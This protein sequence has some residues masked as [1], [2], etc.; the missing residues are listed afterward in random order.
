MKKLAWLGLPLALGLVACPPPGVSADADKDN[1]PDSAEVPGSSYKGI[2]VYSMGARV[3]QR[4]IFLEIDNMTSAEAKLNPQRAALDKFV[5]AF[6]AK[7]IALHIDVGDAF[8]PNFDPANYNLGNAQRLLPYSQSISLT[9]KI[10]FASVKELKSQNFAANRNGV[11]YYMVLGSSQNASGLAGSS[12]RAEIIGDDSM[13][14]FGGWN[15][16]TNTTEKTTQLNN[17]M[18]ST[19]MHEFGHNLGL[20]HG[21]DENLNYKPNYVSIMN[22]MY[23][24][25]CIGPTSGTGIADRFFYSLYGGTK[26]PESGLV[27]NARTSAC[28][29]DFSDGSSSNL[30]ENSLNENAGMGRGAGVVDWNDDETTQTALSLNLNPVSLLGD[31]DDMNSSLQDHDDWS[32]IQIGFPQGGAHLLATPELSDEEAPSAEYLKALGQ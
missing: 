3:G 5:A 1:I 2:D 6:A 8:S 29:I 24:L 11:F 27:N 9:P 25:D 15:L 23:Q 28:K 30:D 26:Y 22:Y 14:T 4:D 12:G 17:I 10:G 16:N 32:N 21:G 31:G 7:K 19:M 18:A 20:R 13:V